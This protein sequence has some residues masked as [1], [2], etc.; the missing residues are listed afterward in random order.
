MSTGG[1]L[2]FNTHFAH[3]EALVHG[4]RAGFLSDVD[5]KHLAQCET[6]EG[7]FK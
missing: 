1:M 4:L 2:T 7:I 3:V 6:M 5:Y